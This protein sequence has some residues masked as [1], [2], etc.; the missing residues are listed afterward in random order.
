MSFTIA[1]FKTMGLT[2]IK[3]AQRYIDVDSIRN[4]IELIGKKK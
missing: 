1:D 2:V 4:E 3:T